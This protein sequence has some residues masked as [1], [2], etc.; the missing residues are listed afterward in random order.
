[1]S[2]HTHACHA[3][4][5]LCLNAQVRIINFPHLL[6]FLFSLSFRWISHK[7]A[8][9]NYKS[10]RFPHWPRRGKERLWITALFQDHIPGQGSD[11][12]GDIYLHST[13]R[14]R[15]P[16]PGLPVTWRFWWPSMV[17]EVWEIGL[18]G[19][20]RS[21]N[22]M[23]MCK[24]DQCHPQSS[25]PLGAKSFKNNWGYTSSQLSEIETHGQRS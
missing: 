19:Q 6:S 14:K 13:L 12:R 4:L 17:W 8:I 22:W 21:Q 15:D 20:W 16:G 1:M 25:T 11:L 24:D 9:P 7:K 18:K 23:I 2:I 3:H 5:C 10:K